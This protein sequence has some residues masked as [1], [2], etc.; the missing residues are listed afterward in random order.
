MAYVQWL[1]MLVL[2]RVYPWL[3]NGTGHDTETV[4]LFSLRKNPSTKV[5]TDQYIAPEAYE[6]Q[7]WF[8]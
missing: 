5:G 8:S 2:G 6:A 4:W 7:S 3:K 1:L